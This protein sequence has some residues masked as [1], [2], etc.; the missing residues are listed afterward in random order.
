M[1]VPPRTSMKTSEG[2]STRSAGFERYDP[3][4]RRRQP[5]FALLAVAL[6]GFRDDAHRDRGDGAEKQDADDFPHTANPSSGF[7]VSPSRLQSH[8]TATIS[9]A[10]G[11]PDVTA[12][13]CLEAARQSA[14]NKPGTGFLPQRIRLNGVPNRP[15]SQERTHAGREGPPDRRPRR[16]DRRPGGRRLSKPSVT[17]SASTRSDTSWCLPAVWNSPATSSPTASGCFST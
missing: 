6:L 17:A 11:L 4:L 12:G 9:V 8:A 14:A 3:A 7:R 1:R 5:A 15:H 13:H 2:D 16:A 10:A